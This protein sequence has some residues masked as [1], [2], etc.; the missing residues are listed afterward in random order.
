MSS[1]QS[2]RRWTA[3]ARGG[4]GVGCLWIALW[5]YTPVLYQLHYTCTWKKADGVFIAKGNT[6][7][8]D[9]Y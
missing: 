5:A 2:V 9:M 1:T 3:F 6:L 7:H 8:C 4:G